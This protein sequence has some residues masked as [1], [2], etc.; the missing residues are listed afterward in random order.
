MIDAHERR[1]AVTFDVPV[2]HIH[3]KLAPKERNERGL[4]KLKKRFYSMMCE[5]NPELSKNVMHDMDKRFSAC[6]FVRNL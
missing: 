5:M 3:A 2:A 1:V 6:R 4:T